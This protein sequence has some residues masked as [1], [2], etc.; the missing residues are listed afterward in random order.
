MSIGQSG[1]VNV[2][3]ARNVRDPHLSMEWTIPTCPSGLEH[4]QIMLYAHCD[5]GFDRSWEASAPSDA[6]RPKIQR[7]TGGTGLVQW[8][9]SGII[10]LLASPRSSKACGLNHTSKSS[11]M[12]T[13]SMSTEF[14]IAH[15]SLGLRAYSKVRSE[16]P[17][18]Q[19]KLAHPRIYPEM[20]PPQSLGKQSHLRLERCR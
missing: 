18:S 17:L 2:V 11:I 3:P 4:N 5:T 12:L 9:P 8:Y 16:F 1:R 7:A 19:H 14:L 13:M 6:V 15:L 10:P 20:N